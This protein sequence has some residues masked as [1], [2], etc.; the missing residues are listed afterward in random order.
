MAAEY[1]SSGIPFFRSLN[2]KPLRIETE[3]L[4]F[5]SPEF[6]NRIRKSRLKPGDVVIFRTGDPGTAT[7]IPI[8]R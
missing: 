7:V 8:V 2:I 5:I 1:G 6:D 3:D 4:K